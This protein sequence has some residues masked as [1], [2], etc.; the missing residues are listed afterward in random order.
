MQLVD[1]G[2][3]MIISLPRILAVA[4]VAGVLGLAMAGCGG[5]STSTVNGQVTPSGSAS[6]L[7]LGG[8]T[9]AYTECSN[10]TPT[11]GTQVT[12]TDPGGK[13]IG[14]A[15]L[16]L[17]SHATISQSGL[18]LYTCNMPFTMKDVPAEPRYG[19]VINNVPGKIWITNVSSLVSLVVSTP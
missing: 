7:G 15:S 16:G 12:V 14:N 13:V 1:C 4:A 10:D 3:R 9:Q 18:T 2:D 5:G 6:A 11:P 17:W 8:D 19:F